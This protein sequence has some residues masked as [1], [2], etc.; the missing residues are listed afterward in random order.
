MASLS[1]SSAIITG[2]KDKTLNPKPQR[3]NPKQLDLRRG[4]VNI[5]LPRGAKPG[6]YMELFKGTLCQAV[7]D[8]KPDLIFVS[9]G[10]DA[11]KD[12]MFRFLKLTDASY[13]AMTEAVMDVR[14]CFPSSSSSH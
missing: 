9:A 5:P 10:F 3:L 14:C 1:C 2:S 8:Y 6:E 11:H 13:R 7:K 4:I 12:D